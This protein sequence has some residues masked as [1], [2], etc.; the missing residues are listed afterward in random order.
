[1]CLIFIVGNKPDESL[2]IGGTHTGILKIDC[3]GIRDRKFLLGFG[4][5]FID[6]M[7]LLGAA[8]EEKYGTKEREQFHLRNGQFHRVS[9]RQKP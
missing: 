3:S 2:I 6:A 7:V 1:M 8:A 9:L 5:Q 4:C